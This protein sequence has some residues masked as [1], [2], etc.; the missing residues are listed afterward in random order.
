[1]HLDLLELVQLG[2]SGQ[3]CFQNDG[4]SVSAWQNWHESVVQTG[5]I[6]TDPLGHGKIIAGQHGSPQLGLKW[7]GSS[8]EGRRSGS[9][10]TQLATCGSLFQRERYWLVRKSGTPKK[11]RG[12]SI[13]CFQALKGNK[14]FFLGKSWQIQSVWTSTWCWHGIEYWPNPW[15]VQ[16][17]KLD[18]YQLCPAPLL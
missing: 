13:L 16:I 15:D 1:M 2:M 17:F 6:C 10:P 3:V 4:W 12:S 11:I 8:R 18:P 7:Q 14:S 9:A 5:W